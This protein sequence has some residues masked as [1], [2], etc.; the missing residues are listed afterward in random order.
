VS[1]HAPPG[2]DWV[3]GVPR[4]GEQRNKSY[5]SLTSKLLRHVRRANE[6]VLIGGDWNEGARTSGPGSPSWL[7]AKGGLKKYRN[8]RIDWEMARGAKLTDMH[9]GSAGGSDHRIVVFTVTRP[10]R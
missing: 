9:V 8:G 4:G 7:A 2:I 5:Q 10:G 6:A 1:V 3:N